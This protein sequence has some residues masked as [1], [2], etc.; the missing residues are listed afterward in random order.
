MFILKV[1]PLNR[2]AKMYNLVEDD[3]F[4]GFSRVLGAKNP[5][6]INFAIECKLPNMCFLQLPQKIGHGRS[7]IG[8]R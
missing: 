7:E 3:A 2:F 5:S 1:Y 4:L 6:I 8:L